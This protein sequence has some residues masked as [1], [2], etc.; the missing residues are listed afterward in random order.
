MTP[1]PRRNSPPVH[2]RCCIHPVRSIGTSGDLH[3]RNEEHVMSYALSPT[4]TRDDSVALPAPDAWLRALVADCLAVD[5]AHLE[6]A[7]S[8]RDDLAADSLDFADIAVALEH[9]IG[10]VVPPSLL[11]RVRTYGDLVAL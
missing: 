5:A 9:D 1:R 7:V 10:I 3:R 6:P 2:G 8:L 4:P 11:A